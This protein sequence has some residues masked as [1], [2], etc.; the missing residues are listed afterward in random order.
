MDDKR[1]TL[2]FYILAGIAGT[3]VSDGLW[4]DTVLTIITALA[5]LN[6]GIAGYYRAITKDVQYSIDGTWKATILIVIGTIYWSV[7]ICQ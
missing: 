3:W 1:V 4:H 2:G 7:M 6:V 5:Y